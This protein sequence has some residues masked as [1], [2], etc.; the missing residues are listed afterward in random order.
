MRSAGDSGVRLTLTLLPTTR[1]FYRK[2]YREMNPLGGSV[3]RRIRR[4][5]TEVVSP[6]R[7]APIGELVT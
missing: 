7:T 5:V 6:V 2:E 1:Q 4:G 3:S